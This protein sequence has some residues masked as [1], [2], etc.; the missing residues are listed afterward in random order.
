MVCFTYTSDGNSWKVNGNCSYAGMCMIYVELSYITWKAWHGKHLANKICP[1]NYFLSW[2]SISNLQL[3]EPVCLNICFTILS[4]NVQ[5]SH[6]IILL[7]SFEP[8]GQEKVTINKAW[9]LEPYFDKLIPIYNLKC[10]NFPKK[11]T[12]F[13]CCFSFLKKIIIRYFNPTFD[14]QKFGENASCLW[15]DFV[16]C[17]LFL[18]ECEIKMRFSFPFRSS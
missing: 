18:M 13:G 2:S 1:Q 8:M 15:T 12:K 4:L 5:V 17:G 6:V 14:G 16:K 3:L 7:P 9:S 11:E 10:N